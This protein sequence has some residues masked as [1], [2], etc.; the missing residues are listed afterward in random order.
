M[1]DKALLKEYSI[2]RAINGVEAVSLAG[3]TR[4]DAILMDIKMPQ[5][6]GLEATR[7]IREFDREVPI[8]ALTANAFD[9]DRENAIKAGCNAFLS[10]PFSKKELESILATYM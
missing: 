10:K 2:I 5:M 4:F 8:V 7:R 6:D 3:K 9:S 1:L